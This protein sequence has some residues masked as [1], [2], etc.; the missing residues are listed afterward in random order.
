M[1]N[2]GVTEGLC[3]TNEENVETEVILRLG[4]SH[5]HGVTEGFHLLAGIVFR[6]ASVSVGRLRAPVLAGIS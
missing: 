1:M 3:N 5:G 6:S 2:A 4:I